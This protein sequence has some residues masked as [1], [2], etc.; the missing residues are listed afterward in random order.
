MKLSKPILMTIL[1]ASLIVAWIPSAA[2]EDW[3]QFR[4]PN[5]SGVSATTGLPSEFGPGKNMI[6]KTVLPPRH[7]SPVK[8]R[9]LKVPPVAPLP[10]LT[11]APQPTSM[12]LAEQAL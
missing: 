3:S 6:W 8:R 7:S 4:G 2:A 11:G 1:I 5:G 10:Q 12:P 9:T